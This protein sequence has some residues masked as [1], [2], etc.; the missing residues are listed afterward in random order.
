MNIAPLLMFPGTAQRAMRKYVALFPG[1]RIVS[2]E[3]YAAGEPGAEG[4]VKRAVFELHGSR[5]LCI[6]SPVAHD[7]S[8]TPS[9]SLFVDCDTLDQFERALAAL[10]QNGKV[11]MP[12]AAYGFSQRFAWIADDFG[13]SWQLNVP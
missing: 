2:L 9:I 13:V 6:D 11:F 5:F 7:F 10:S 12:A 4:T 8:F 1:S 3:T